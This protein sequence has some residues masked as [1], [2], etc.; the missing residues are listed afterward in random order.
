M[1]YFI[2]MKVIKTS[3]RIEK[4]KESIIKK[5]LSKYEI[6]FERDAFFTDSLT[7]A[8]GI[9]GLIRSSRRIDAIIYQKIQGKYLPLHTHKTVTDEEIE[10]ILSLSKPE[11]K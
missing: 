3:T 4:T 11:E 8:K 2:K 7:E 1:K 9:R 6:R 5:A 10:E